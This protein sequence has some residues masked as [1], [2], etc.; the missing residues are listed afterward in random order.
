METSESKGRD[1]QEQW[2]MEEWAAGSPGGASVTP[3]QAHWGR[4][5]LT[6][7]GAGWHEKWEALHS[8]FENWKLHRS[9]QR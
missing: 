9:Y 5:M 4:V 6:G 8:A 7:V 3:K 1:D 2:E